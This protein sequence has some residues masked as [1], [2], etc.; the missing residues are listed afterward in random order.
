MDAQFAP[1]ELP[2]IL[3]ALTIADAGRKI[4]LTVEVAQHLGNDVVRCIAMSTTDGLT[5]GMDVN[6]TGGPITVPVG[7]QTLG[8]VFNLLG[9]R[10]TK[11]RSGVVGSQRYPIHRSA[12]TLEDQS[13]NHRDSGNRHQSRRPALPVS[14]RRQDR[15]VRRRGC[16]QDRHHSGTDPQHRRRVRRRLRVRGRRRAHPRGQR[17]VAGNVLKPNS[18]TLR[19]RRPMSLTRRPWSS[20]R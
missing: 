2:N 8:R 3:N 10:L 9:N 13:S 17:P 4:S 7:N 19:A 12:P 15:P 5:R 1:G 6:D 11:G 16:R 18:R 14:Q 20:A